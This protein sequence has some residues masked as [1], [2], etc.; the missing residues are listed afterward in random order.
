[1]SAT[2]RSVNSM[3]APDMSTP[4]ERR[5]MALAVQ[6]HFRALLNV[7]DQQTSESLQIE[8]ASIR[9]SAERGLQLANRLLAEIDRGTSD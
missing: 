1:M 5:A 3:T 9:S 4:D 8:M 2:R 7:L 6:Q